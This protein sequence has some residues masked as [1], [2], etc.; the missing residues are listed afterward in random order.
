L[1]HRGGEKKGRKD[2]ERGK[3]KTERERKDREGEK[4][5]IRGGGV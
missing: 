1:E 3:E 2:R 5:R 4:R